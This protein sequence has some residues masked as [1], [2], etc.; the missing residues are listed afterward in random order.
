[1]SVQVPAAVMLHLEALIVLTVTG[2]PSYAPA[3]NGNYT[4]KDERV[5]DAYVWKHATSSIWIMRNRKGEW[6]I[7]STEA[8]D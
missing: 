8:K 1:M 6:M 4:I 5:N 7:T 2:V 3:I